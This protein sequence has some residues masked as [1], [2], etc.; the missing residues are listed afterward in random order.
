M[1]TVAAPTADALRGSAAFGWAIHLRPRLR[2]SRGSRDAARRA[3]EELARLEV[4]R[5]GRCSTHRCS[6]ARRFPSSM[7]V[8]ESPVYGCAGGVPPRGLGAFIGV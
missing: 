2:T 1:G 7:I 6:E 3:R 8:L 5:R 4:Q